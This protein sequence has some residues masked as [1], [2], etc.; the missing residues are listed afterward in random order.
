MLFLG[1]P[2]TLIVVLPAMSHQHQSYRRQKTQHRR[3]LRP[4]P[5][6]PPP[7]TPTT[8]TS[9]R[10]QHFGFTRFLTYGSACQ[11]CGFNNQRIDLEYAIPLAAATNRTL[12]V[13]NVL[14]SPHHSPC[15]WSTAS[16]VDGVIK[17]LGEER[18]RK[19][20]N[21]PGLICDK[22]H[23]L[24]KT[25]SLDARLFFDEEYIREATAKYQG[26]IWQEDFEQHYAHL[27]RPNGERAR[28]TAATTTTT[29]TATAAAAAAAAV[30]DWPIIVRKGRVEPS[31]WEAPV[32]HASHLHKG[33]DPTR[34]LSP[35][36]AK[37]TQAA[38]ARDGK[39]VVYSKAVRDLAAYIIETFAGLAGAS[40]GGGRSGL[41][42]RFVCVHA[43]LGDWLDY[44]KPNERPRPSQRWDGDAYGDVIAKYVKDRDMPIFVATNPE[45]YTDIA[46]AFAGKF[47]KLANASAA[48][49]MLKDRRYSN[50]FWSCVEQ[51]VC[52]QADVFVGTKGSTVTRYVHSRRDALKKKTDLVDIRRFVKK[53]PSNKAT[54]SLL[55]QQ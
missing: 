48:M 3:E 13:R 50:D 7:P 11:D 14:C 20:C 18:W 22:D 53:K 9:Q 17:L 51:N 49:K 39:P 31:E 26:F 44:D 5:P 4:P 8:T 46:A 41:L 23:F 34:L 15:P 28:A 30:A 25:H 36:I 47:K 33:S 52:E 43:R 45:N 29:T 42:R 19:A 21:I 27:F 40:R 54:R 35:S 32:V 10:Q 16:A 12:V 38:Y 1:V 6:P 55:L 24:G 2:L 37:Q